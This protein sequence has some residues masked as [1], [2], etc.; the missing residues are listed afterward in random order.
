MLY[1][2]DQSD[3][4][5]WKARCNDKEGLVPFN[6]GPSGWRCFAGVLTFFPPVSE[7]TETIDNPMH[8]AS[9]RGSSCLQPRLVANEKMVSPRQHSVPE[10]GAQCGSLGQRPR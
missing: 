1:V 5:W 6:Y 9:K 2:L 7:N 3:K 10:G 8:E 4:N